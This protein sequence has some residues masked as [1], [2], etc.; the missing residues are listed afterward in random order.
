MKSFF[1]FFFL[2]PFPILMCAMIE[3]TTA[4]NVW[5]HCSFLAFLFVAVCVWGIISDARMD[6]Y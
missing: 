1:A 4:A 2:F 3:N 6:R 5:Y